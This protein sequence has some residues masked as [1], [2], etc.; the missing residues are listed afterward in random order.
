M[1]DTEEILRE[2]NIEAE[3]GES[4]KT[5]LR[6]CKEEKRDPYSLVEAALKDLDIE[7]IDN[8]KMTLT[9]SLN[10]SLM[11]REKLIRNNFTTYIKC[12]KTLEELQEMKVNRD[13][14]EYF[15]IKGLAAMEALISP[16]IRENSEIHRKQQQMDFILNN[17]LLF[18]AETILNDY[19]KVSDFTS[20]LMDYALVKK[21]AA[22]FKSS[23]FIS[24]LFSKTIPILAKFKIEIVRR[25]ETCKSI[26]E[27]LHYFKIYMQ[28]D[29]EG[30]NKAFATLLTIAKAEIGARKMPAAGDY[31]LHLR[32]IREYTEAQT[33]TVMY[34]I[35]SMKA[36]DL[37]TWQTKEMHDFL[38]N[39]VGAYAGTLKK[40]MLACLKSESLA[41]PEDA[42]GLLKKKLHIVQDIASSIEAVVDRLEAEGIDDAAS[43]HEVGEVFSALT[44]VL[45]KGMEKE[46][47]Q[48]ISLLVSSSEKI[49]GVR[50]HLPAQIKEFLVKMLTRSEEG[51]PDPLGYLVKNLSK[52]TVV[53]FPKI[54]RLLSEKEKKEVLHK[55]DELRER[56]K[57]V[58]K[59]QLEARLKQASCDEEFLMEIVRMK[60][61]F[62]ENHLKNI[63]TEFQIISEAIAEI[64][65]K[66]DLCRYLLRK[67][68]PENTIKKIIDHSI[69]NHSRCRKQFAILNDWS[70]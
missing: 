54:D 16:I 62:Q 1:K 46:D 13:S 29:P 3:C 23:K 8:A 43:M 47:T 4:Q 27:S 17:S 20:F 67:Y 52:A 70:E 49:Q 50:E 7:D 66:T 51:E 31:L 25:I 40:E 53:L 68:V 55:A 34:M 36:V 28:V 63:A 9:N 56:I 18:N 5:H 10:E 64:G 14:S 58:G 12:R 21:E 11:R 57:S 45:W 38:V 41:R 32:G 35:N 33:E 44:R 59:M 2:F 61:V 30:H 15:D 39:A 37:V 42:V 65:L 60:V 6:A 24:Y 26:S 48:V 19:L 22:R 69:L